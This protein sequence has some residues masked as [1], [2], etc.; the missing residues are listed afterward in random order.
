MKQLSYATLSLAFA[1]T[2]AFT[3]CCTLKQVPC[4]AGGTAL[5]SPCPEKLYN[6]VARKVEVNAKASVDVLDKVKVQGIDAAVKNDVVQLRAQ[7]DQFSGR[8]RDVLSLAATQANKQPCNQELQKNLQDMLAAMNAQSAALAELATKVNGSLKGGGAT[9]SPVDETTLKS[10]IGAYQSG[11]GQD[12]T[13][14]NNA[15]RTGGQ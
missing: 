10:A 3:G 12:L 2:I 4:P 13:K 11:A 7:I 6:D 9:G 1:T 8:A 14:L 5:Y 15:P